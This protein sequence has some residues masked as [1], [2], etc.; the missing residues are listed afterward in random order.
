MNP[1]NPTPTS[2]RVFSGYIAATFLA[3]IVDMGVR[4]ILNRY[5][6]V[7]LLF[8]LALFW[9]AAIFITCIPCFALSAFCRREGA[10]QLAFFVFVGFLLGLYT[11]AIVTSNVWGHWYTWDD[12]YHPTLHQRIRNWSSYCVDGATGGAIFWAIAGRLYR[13]PIPAQSS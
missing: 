6:F 8:N 3:C 2:E 9:L 1:E 7:G 13:K 5:D 4:G 12:S 11:A 10:D